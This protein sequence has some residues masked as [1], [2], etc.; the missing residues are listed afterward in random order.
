M[1][2]RDFT[3]QMGVGSLFLLQSCGLD[4]QAGIFKYQNTI[5][6]DIVLW[7]ADTKIVISFK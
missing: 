4:A 3:E 2:E 5:F 7:T 6:Y 1:K